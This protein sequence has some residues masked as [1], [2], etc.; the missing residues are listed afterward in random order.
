VK[1]VRDGLWN[2]KKSPG[3]Y[4]GKDVNILWNGDIHRIFIE[5]KCG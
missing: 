1:K 4:A 2:V 3:E 5:G